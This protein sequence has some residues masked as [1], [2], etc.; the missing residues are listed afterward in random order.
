LDQK[1]IDMMKIYDPGLNSMQKKHFEKLPKKEQSQAEAA[2]KQVVLPKFSKFV[3][4]RGQ[5]Q[6]ITSK[7]VQAGR[8]GGQRSELNISV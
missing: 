3:N 1:T 4:K 5:P 8:D 7:Q 6:T 2:R